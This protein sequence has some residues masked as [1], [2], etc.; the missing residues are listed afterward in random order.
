MCGYKTSTMV[1]ERKYFETKGHTNV[2]KSIKAMT[3][4]R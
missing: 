4:K 1:Q 2:V 3:A